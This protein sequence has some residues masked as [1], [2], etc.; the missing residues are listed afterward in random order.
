MTAAAKSRPHIRLRMYDSGN[1]NSNSNNN[2]NGRLQ[3]DPTRHYS[4]TPASSVE[5]HRYP[6][7]T[8]YRSGTVMS[9]R[10][11]TTNASNEDGATLVHHD[12][13]AVYRDGKESPDG[14]GGKD[15][16]RHEYGH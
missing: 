6:L 13:Y 5:N 3:A 16:E 2:S 8:F 15:R 14:G 12:S 4:M 11:T 10:S 7:E 1:S 9:T